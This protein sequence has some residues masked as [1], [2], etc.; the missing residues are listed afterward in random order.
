MSAF[1][2]GLIQATLAYYNETA[3][4]QIEQLDEEGKDVRFL[5]IKEI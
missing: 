4:I 5:I 1:A 3:T 2:Y